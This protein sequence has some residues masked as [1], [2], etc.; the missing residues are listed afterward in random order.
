MSDIAILVVQEEFPRD[1]SGGQ[2]S[3]LATEFWGSQEDRMRQRTQSGF[4]RSRIESFDALPCAVDIAVSAGYGRV[5]LA[6]TITVY[7]GESAAPLVRRIV[8]RVEG[9]AQKFTE[10]WPESSITLRFIQRLASRAVIAHFGAG[11]TA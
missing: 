9:L 11:R 3:N 2:K 5:S 8:H 4:L 7:G 6:G 1:G 10:A